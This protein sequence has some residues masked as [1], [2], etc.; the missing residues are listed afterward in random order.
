MN[1]KIIVNAY[2]TTKQKLISKLQSYNNL[3]VNFNVT[4]K[5]S[6]FKKHFKAI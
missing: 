4:K 2:N 5:L 3:K 1:I 6:S